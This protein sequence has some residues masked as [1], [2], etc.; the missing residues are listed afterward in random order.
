MAS[1]SLHKSRQS[2]SLTFHTVVGLHDLPLWGFI[3]CVCFAELGIEPRA[4]VKPS[5]TLALN[6]IPNC[7]ALN[8]NGAH[9]CIC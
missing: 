1:Q 7:G 3:N 5:S 9:R 2:F 4:L 6:H 8:E